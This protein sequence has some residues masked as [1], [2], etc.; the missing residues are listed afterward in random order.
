MV[1]TISAL[2]ENHFGVLT[3][4]A[5]LFA[6]R[7][8][9]IQ[10]LTVGPTEDETVSRMTIVV[11]GDDKIIDQVK[12]QLNKLI[13]TIKVIDL[14]GE[15]FVDRELLLI[16]VTASSKTRPDILQLTEVFKGSVVDIAP[17]VVTIEVSGN[18]KKID[19]FIAMLKPYGVREMARTGRIA[20]GRG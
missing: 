13:D 5:G 10:S 4:V 15:D 2:V 17:A 1:H 9:N 7:G 14:T 20:L 3:R 18:P 19:A 11:E 8:Y 6:S 16:K 12:K